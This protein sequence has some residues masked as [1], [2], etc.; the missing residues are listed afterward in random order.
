MA[1]LGRVYLKLPLALSATDLET[2]K[3]DEEKGRKYLEDAIK[4]GNVRA[5][6]DLGTIETKANNMDHAIRHFTLAAAAGHE[7]SVKVLWGCFHQKV[8]EKAELVKTLRAHKE[9]CD[10][11]NSEERERCK[12][13]EKAR[14]AGDNML[15]ELLKLYYE[16]DINV[17]QLNEALKVHKKHS[18]SITEKQLKEAFER[19]M[20]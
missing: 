16:G 12:L 5:R 4:M 11:M 2:T 9:A 14:E 15:L 7:N 17:K 3:A 1:E 13:H 6:F 19:G 10:S 8:L 20:Q 18:G